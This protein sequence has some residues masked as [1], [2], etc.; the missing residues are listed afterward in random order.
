[1]ISVLQNNLKILKKIIFFKFKF[2]MNNI[3]KTIINT[4]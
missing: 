2:Q 3:L 4:L 1:M